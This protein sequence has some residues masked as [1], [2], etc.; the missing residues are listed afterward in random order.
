MAN[1]CICMLFD[2]VES[3]TTVPAEGLKNYGFKQK[4][5][6]A[7]SAPPPDWNRFIVFYQLFL[8]CKCT[9]GPY[10]SSSA[11]TELVELH[12]A[13]GWSENLGGG[14]VVI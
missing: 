11:G 10:T 13:V 6:R 5:R 3:A 4:N 9:P 12:R 1:A 14:Q 2:C 7:E 8:G